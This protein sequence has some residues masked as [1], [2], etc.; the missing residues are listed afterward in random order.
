MKK[1]KMILVACM[2]MS[3]SF[4]SVKAE[5]ITED[6][7]SDMTITRTIPSTYSVKIPKTIEL[8]TEATK[9]FN[10]NITGNIAPDKILKVSASSKVSMTRQGD[11]TYAKD[12][13][14]SFGGLSLN[15]TALEK[16]MDA[17]GNISFNEIKAGVYSGVAT[18]N[19]S[20][21]TIVG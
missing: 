11:S 7:A 8:G 14:M 18:F 21:E 13:S 6:G 19:I 2:M 9:S 15:H 12:A 1:N 5:E 16:G 20:L 3:C 10:V 17:S 4:M